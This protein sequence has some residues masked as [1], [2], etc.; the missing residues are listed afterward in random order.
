MINKINDFDIIVNEWGSCQY[1]GALHIYKLF[2]EELKNNDNHINKTLNEFNIKDFYPAD[3]NDINYIKKNIM[4]YFIENDNHSD[5]ELIE[6]IQNILK[7][8]KVDEIFIL[9]KELSFDL[10]TAVDTI[11][12][13]VFS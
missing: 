4:I 13:Q 12:F 7:I 5:N 3:N 10:W 6:I 1:A 9:F 8:N 11:F 2:L